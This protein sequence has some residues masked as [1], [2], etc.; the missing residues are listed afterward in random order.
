MGRRFAAGGPSPKSLDAGLDE[1]EFVGEHH[2]LN[3]VTQP[4][5]E[6]DP[7]ARV[8]YQCPE[9]TVLL[10]AMLDRPKDRVDL[11]VTL[12]LPAPDRLDWLRNH[13]RRIHPGHAWL[14]HDRLA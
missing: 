5:F 4:E 12:P 6:Q 7:G 9:I 14:E 13:L 11:E 2:G 10:K 3:P 1:A 8:S